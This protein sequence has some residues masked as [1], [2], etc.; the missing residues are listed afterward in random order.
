MSRSALWRQEAGVKERA[1]KA[2]NL[3][4]SAVEE[5]RSKPKKALIPLHGPDG[6][7]S[8]FNLN[9]MLIQNII[10]SQYF[11][12]SIEKLTD[13]NAV[14]DEIYYEVKHC[15]PWTPGKICI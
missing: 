15:E 4:L 11:Q 6:G 12:K 9:P 8:A 3:F 1:E 7:S 2:E 14:V 13:W 10:K 5:G